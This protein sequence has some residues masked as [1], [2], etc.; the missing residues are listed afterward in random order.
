MPRCLR[1]QKNYLSHIAEVNII[2]MIFL[3]QVFHVHCSVKL[4]REYLP[5]YTIYFYE[6]HI[7]FLWESILHS[8]LP[9]H[10]RCF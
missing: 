7:I 9:E 10:R 4:R 1:G 3:F 8:S 5:Y 6:W 2:K